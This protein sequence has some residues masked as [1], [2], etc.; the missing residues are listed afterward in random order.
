MAQP[1]PFDML[2]TAE[3]LALREALM[4]ESLMSGLRKIF[5]FDHRLHS[6][7]M[8]NEALSVEP[9]V[10]RIIQFASKSR[11][12]QEIFITIKA[13]MHTLTPQQRPQL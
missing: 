4:N 1:S 8:E 5:D 11:S 12:A 9:N 13:R 10:H 7:S 6:E 2:N 3:L